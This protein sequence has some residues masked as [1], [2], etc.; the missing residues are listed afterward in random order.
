MVTQFSLEQARVAQASPTTMA[1]FARHFIE[2]IQPLL[3]LQYHD[4]NWVLNMD[5]TAVFFS[6]LPRTTIDETGAKP[7]TVCDALNGSTR[8]TTA[9]A[10]TAAG[11]GLKPLIVMKGNIIY[12]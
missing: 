9:I 1:A 4:M 10:I 3:N 8:V 6:M 7:V 12:E 11:S 5:Q 2:N